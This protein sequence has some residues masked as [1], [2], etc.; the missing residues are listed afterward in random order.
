VSGF[1]LLPDSAGRGVTAASVDDKLVFFGELGLAVVF[2]QGPNF[3]WLQNDYS[4]PAFIQAAEGVRYDTPHVGLVP[5]GVW[6]MTGSGPRMLTRGLATARGPTGLDMGAQAKTSDGAQLG[7]CLVVVHPAKPQVLFYE[8]VTSTLFI[9]DYMRDQWTTRADIP[10]PLG[11]SGLNFARGQLYFLTN[12]TVANNPLLFSDRANES[13]LPLTVETGWMTFSGLQRFQRLTDV[14]VLLS[15]LNKAM[16][17][18]YTVVVSVFTDFDPVTPTQTTTAT[19]DS[20]SSTSQ[21]T[22]VAHQIVRQQSNAFKFVITVTPLGKGG[23]FALSGMLARVGTKKG[24]ARLP[25]SRRA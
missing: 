23:N 4:Q 24:G 20:I 9:Y 16:G 8:D 12:D 19:T 11:R 2:G 5:D 7:R 21:S 6:Y 15:L 18:A 13:L 10:K 22:Q 14:Q 17:S 1:G 3:N 25:N